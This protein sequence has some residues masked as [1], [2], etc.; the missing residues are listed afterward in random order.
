MIAYDAN[1][2]CCWIFFLS[3]IISIFSFPLHE[4]RNKI[5]EILISSDY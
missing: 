2:G 3:S 1:G 4:R 5:A